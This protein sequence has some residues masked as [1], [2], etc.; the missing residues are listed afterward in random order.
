MENLNDFAGRMKLILDASEECAR[1][2][3]EARE[4]EM[5]VLFC[6]EACRNRFEK[7]PEQYV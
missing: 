7:D 3:P 6:V 2:R 5:E 1:R 4:R